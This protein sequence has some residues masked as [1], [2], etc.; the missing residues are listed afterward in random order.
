MAHLWDR[1]VL[2]ASSWHGLEEVGTFTDAPSMVEHGERTGAWPTEVRIADMVC[3]F[4]SCTFPVESHG[5]V[6]ASYR[7]E[8]ARVVGVVGSR[9]E[10]T[11]PESWRELVK[12]AVMAGA[13]PTGA[14]SLDN[15]RK[16]LGT[17]QVNGT[18]GGIVTNL[19]LADSFDGSSHLTVGTTSVRVVCANTLAMA[20]GQDGAG[21]AK[22]RHTS[23]LN[24][25]V[26]ALGA[27]I[28]DAITTG[29][30]L[31]EAFSRAAEMRLTRERAD[32]IL[33]ELF[34][35]APADAAP[36]V[37]TRAQNARDEVLRAMRLDVNQLG[38]TLGTIW[39]AATYIVDRHVDGTARQLRSGDPLMSLMFGSRGDRVA[40]I[41]SVMTRALAAA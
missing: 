11:T 27:A 12:A 36:G 25:R 7:S 4:D 19:L 31:R 41:Q 22:L 40:E 39:N 2:H 9:Y 18:D 24:D 37:V 5:A 32:A 10:P 3:R 28:G 35:P 1:G 30:K 21:M 26:T 16:V 13:Q 8:P 23:S 34:P 20:M 14:F 15:G 38:S 33:D 29:K 6:L 17:F